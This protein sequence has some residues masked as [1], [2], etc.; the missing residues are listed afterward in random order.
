[1]LKIIAT[2]VSCLVATQA[3]ADC[4]LTK[5]KIGSLYTGADMNS[6]EF[7]T[8]C[9][10]EFISKHG[11]GQSAVMLFQIVDPRGSILV[12]TANGNERMTGYSVTMA[13]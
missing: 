12:I 2:T 5:E 6:V 1:M 3:G 9:E 7:H 11:F 10:P 13:R 8:G 4:L